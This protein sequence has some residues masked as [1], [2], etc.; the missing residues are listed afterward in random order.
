MPRTKKPAGAAVD[1]R[2]G[3]RADLAVVQGQ[4]FDPPAGLSD[5]SLIFW[6]TY[7]DD[8]V[9]SVHTAVDRVILTRWISELDRYFKLLRIADADP[10]VFGSQGQPVENPAYGTAHR[11]LAAVQYCEKQLGV[12]PLHRSALGISVVTEAKSLADLNTG[13]GGGPVGGPKPVAAKRAPRD[14]RVIDIAT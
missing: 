8:R 5:E 3:R 14:P 1:S 11:A 9:S 10:V 6:D 4:R 13:F 7:W 2:N 12:G